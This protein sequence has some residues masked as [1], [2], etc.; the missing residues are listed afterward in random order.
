MATI[1]D[2][3]GS[4]QHVD[5]SQLMAGTYFIRVQ[6]AAGVETIKFVKL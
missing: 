1:N 6:S 5:V 4:T 2:L 3:L